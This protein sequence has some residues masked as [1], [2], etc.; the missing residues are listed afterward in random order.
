MDERYSPRPIARWYMG[1]A[2]ASLAFMLLICVA[3][4]VHLT[5][6][7]AS[8]ALDERALYEAEPNWV[9]GALGLTGV[10]GSIGAALLLMRRKLAELV[11][12]VSLA[13]SA[14]WLAGLLLVP[15]LRELLTT[16]EIAA[17]FAICA[18]AWTIY[19]FAHHSRQRG[20]L[21]R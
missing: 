15:K 5:T 2:L 18:I 16:G 7:P 9:S 20:W 11:L 10:F 17:A 6:N 21:C 13:A 14:L 19:W 8:L 1:A 12:L 3:Y 4:A